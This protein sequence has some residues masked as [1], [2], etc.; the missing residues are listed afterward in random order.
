MPLCDNPDCIELRRLASALLEYHMHGIGW[1][2]GEGALPDGVYEDEES[3]V[4][5]VQDLLEGH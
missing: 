5:A 4:A 2:D 3:L 1:A